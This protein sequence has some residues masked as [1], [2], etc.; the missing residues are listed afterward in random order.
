MEKTFQV[1]Y[2][3]KYIAGF[4]TGKN[5]HCHE[6]FTKKSDAIFFAKKDGLQVW[7]D[8]GVYV[9]GFSEITDLTEFLK[10]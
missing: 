2:E 10:T 6:T 8:N 4:L 1:N 9:Q 3:K 7:D 5:Y